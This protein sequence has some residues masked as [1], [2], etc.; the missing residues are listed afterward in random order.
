MTRDEMLTMYH[1]DS[2]KGKILRLVLER[3]PMTREDIVNEL[4]DYTKGSIIT[5]IYMLL[6]KKC[7]VE[8]PKKPSKKN[9]VMIGTVMMP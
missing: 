1:P 2:F 5:G 8:G 9:K 6:Y 7:L 3:G 4:K